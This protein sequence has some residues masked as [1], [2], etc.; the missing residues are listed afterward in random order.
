LITTYCPKDG[1]NKTYEPNSNALVEKWVDST[2]QVLQPR[3][4]KM[5]KGSTSAAGPNN[6]TKSKKFSYNNNYK[7]KNLMTRTQRRRYQRY[8]K[9]SAKVFA[10]VDVD[11]KGKQKAVKLAKKPVKERLF[12]PFLPL[13]EK[14]VEDEEMDS[15]FMDSEPNFDVLSNVVLILLAEYD[16]VYEVDDIEED[17]D[18]E[19]MANHRPMC[20]YVT[21]YGCVKEQQAMFEK[22]NGSLQEK[23]HFATFKNADCDC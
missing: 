2:Q 12:P 4:D 5:V 19:N 9:A 18:P 13:M 17:F 6:P 14:F 20:Y 7:G 15:D 1:P 10:D 8:K 16:I 23:L 3:K 11:P 22:P 21:N